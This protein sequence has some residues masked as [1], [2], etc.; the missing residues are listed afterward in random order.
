MAIASQFTVTFI[1]N[2]W[3]EIIIVVLAVISYFALSRKPEIKEITKVE[4]VDRIVEKE[5]IVEKIVVKDKKK[6]TTVEKPDG[7]KITTEIDES[8]KT[9]ENTIVSE[10]E[11]EERKKVEIITEKQSKSRYNLGISAKLYPDTEYSA[12]AYMRL[13]DLPITIGPVLYVR[14]GES[15]QFSYGVG[16]QIEI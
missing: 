13:G 1:K 5:I 14:T 3:R 16:I 7:T 8:T 10:T 4:Y 12:G 9:D 11:K 15:I 2:R 6:R